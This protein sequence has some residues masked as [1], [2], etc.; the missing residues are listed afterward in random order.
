MVTSTPAALLVSDRPVMVEADAKPAVAGASKKSNAAARAYKRILNS[1]YFNN[2][3]FRVFAILQAV[4]GA[5][6]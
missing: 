3:K 2:P 5:L 1:V 4:N 6:G